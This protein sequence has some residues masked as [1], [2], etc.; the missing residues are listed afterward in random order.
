MEANDVPS[1]V[2]ENGL[3]S[4]LKEVEPNIVNFLS[5]LGLIFVYP[6]LG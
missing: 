5:D 1:G 3:K 6:C 4:P 2:E